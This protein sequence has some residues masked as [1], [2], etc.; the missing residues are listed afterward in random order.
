MNKIECTLAELLNI[1]TTAR[2]AIQGIKEK[3]VALGASSSGT[4][5]KGNDKKKKGKTSVVKPTGGVA[6]N[7]GKAIVMEEPS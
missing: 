3:E 5:K 2:K 7:K 4:K 6:K 1:L